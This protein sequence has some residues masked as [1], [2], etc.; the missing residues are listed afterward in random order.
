MPLQTDRRIKG[1]GPGL[2]PTRLPP[3]VA[4]HCRTHPCATLCVPIQNHFELGWVLQYTATR[5]GSRVG[6]SPGPC[7]LIY[8][9]ESPTLLRFARHLHFPIVPRFARHL[10]SPSVP[11]F[12]RHFLFH[13]FPLFSIFSVSFSIF[14]FFPLLSVCSVFPVFPCFSR[15][16]PFFP[17]CFPFFRLIFMIFYY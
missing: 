6:P 2:G 16:F 7:P 17:F 13:Y 10:N 14:Q 11:R 3:R 8:V 9:S 5:G 15:F 4:G 12:A 1:Q